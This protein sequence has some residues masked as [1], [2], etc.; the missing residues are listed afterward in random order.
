MFQETLVVLSSSVKSE[1]CKIL[2]NT[3]KWTHF[4][5]VLFKALFSSSKYHHQSQFCDELMNDK[6]HNMFWSTRLYPRCNSVGNIEGRSTAK[7]VSFDL[8]YVNIN[9]SIS[10]WL[11]VT[12]PVWEQHQ[13]WRLLHKYIDKPAEH[14]VKRHHWL[15]S[16]ICCLPQQLISF[17]HSPRKKKGNEQGKIDWKSSRWQRS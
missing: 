11:K 15:P 6:V 1:S 5:F 16:S 14:W 13:L 2:Q 10:F 17:P 4:C 3:M 9:F 12:L 7:P 8:T